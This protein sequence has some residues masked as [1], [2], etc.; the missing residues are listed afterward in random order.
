MD[1][2]RLVGPANAAKTMVGAGYSRPQPLAVD[3][4]ICGALAG[5]LA[6]FVTHT[7]RDV[8]P[9]PFFMPTQVPVE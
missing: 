3:F 1:F 4:F 7:S 8:S 6:L 5:W 2:V 9:A